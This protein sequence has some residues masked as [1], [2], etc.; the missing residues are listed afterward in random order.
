MNAC[1]FGRFLIMSEYSARK[2]WCVCKCSLKNADVASYKKNGTT[3]LQK[4][5]CPLI[6]AGCQE[7]L[8]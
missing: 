8:L 1:H 6:T 3:S 2:K 7:L 5:P 4:R